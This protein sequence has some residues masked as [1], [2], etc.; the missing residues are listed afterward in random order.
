[1]TKTHITYQ[2]RAYLTRGGYRRLA[3]ALRKCAWLY[4]HLLEQRIRVYRRSGKT[5][6]YYTQTRY[7]TNLRSRKPYFDDVHTR[8]WRGVT[9]RLDRSYKAFFRRVKDGT[10]KPGFPRFKSSRRW[11]TIEIPDPTP[12]MVNERDGRWVV[13]VKGLPIM[14][15]RPRREIPPSEDLKTLTITLKPTGA[16]VS[17]TYEV[18]REETS[19]GRWAAQGFGQLLSPDFGCEPN[20]IC[21]LSQAFEDVGTPQSGCEPNCMIVDSIMV[22]GAVTPQSG[23]GPNHS[24]DEADTPIGL[25]LGIT[26]RLTLSDGRSVERRLTDGDRIKALQRRISRCKRNSGGQ[27]KLYRQLARLKFREA[28]RNRNECH[29]ITTDLVR[30]HSLIAVEDLAIRNMVRSARGTVEEPGTNVKAKSG[31]NRSITE[32]TWGMLVGQL[33][34]K[35]GWAGA[36]LVKVEAAYTSQTCSGCGVVDS[37]SRNGKR[38]DCIDCGLSLDADINAAKNILARGI[39]ASER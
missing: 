22:E 7:L 34:Y 10:E 8:V 29:R 1:M 38:F 9:H 16:Y 35:S 33:E 17:M 24:H 25:D 12:N 27:R 26:D 13:K 20:P 36:K 32:Q 5:C 6:G 15:I 23:C 31:L 39:M 4:N 21:R 14:R 37:G 11:K 30:R 18:E 19:L 3:E 28:V 2:E